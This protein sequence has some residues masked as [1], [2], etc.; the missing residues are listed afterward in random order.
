M[1]LGA[2][3][4]IG[5][6]NASENPTGIETTYETDI[7]HETFGRNASENPTGIETYLRRPDLKPV[8]SQRIRKPNRD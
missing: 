8:E 7:P 6:R 4:G 3:R 5:G 1:R 2:G